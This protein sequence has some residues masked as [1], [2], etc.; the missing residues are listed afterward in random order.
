CWVFATA[1]FTIKNQ[2]FPLILGS[3]GGIQPPQEPWASTCGR[4]ALIWACPCQN[5]QNCLV[6]ASQIQPLRNGKRTK[7]VLLNLIGRAS[8]NFLGSTRSLK[9][10]PSATHDLPV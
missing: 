5:W 7:I 8:S 2:R 10:Q 1:P 9:I 3:C 4:N 6:S